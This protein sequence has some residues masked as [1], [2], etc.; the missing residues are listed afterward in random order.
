MRRFHSLWVLG[1]FVILAAVSQSPSGMLFAMDSSSMQ[2]EV[3]SP[4]G[5]ADSKLLK[6]ISP[7]L[8]NL[9]GKKIGLFANYKRA[10]VPIAISLQKRLRSMYPDAEVSIYHSDQWNVTEIETENREAFKKWVQGND[11][12]ILLVGD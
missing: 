10:A 7:R 8:D 2:Y 4:W 11:A 9:S 12:I 6:G 1:M 5:E 3:L